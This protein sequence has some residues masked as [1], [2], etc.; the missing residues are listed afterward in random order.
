MVAPRRDVGRRGF[1]LS[2]SF[3]VI[4]I[5]SVVIFTLSLVILSKFWPISSDVPQALRDELEG[6]IANILTQ[7]QRV[8]VYPALLTQPRGIHDLAL[9]G[10]TNAKQEKRDF[11]IIVANTAGIDRDG[12]NIMLEPTDVDRWILYK[13]GPFT[14]ERGQQQRTDLLTH[15]PRRT[16]NAI[17]PRGSYIF[18]IC[19][20]DVAVGA[21]VD[22]VSTREKCRNAKPETLKELPLFTGHPYKL[23]ID[24]E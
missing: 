1:E 17:T 12:N 4:L 23:Q 5:I 11:Y 13:Q 2:I 19:V 6:E 21:S 22:V 14:V 10:W 16:G 15:P 18:N 24:V 7:D 9:V 8:V 20:I 3:L